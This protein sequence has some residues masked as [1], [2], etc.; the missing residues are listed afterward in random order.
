MIKL[1]R[2][3]GL[4]VSRVSHPRSQPDQPDCSTGFYSPCE[5]FQDHSGEGE[6]SKRN[7][8][9]MVHKI[10]DPLGILSPTTLLPVTRILEIEVKMG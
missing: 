5:D 1:A 6:I 4:G 7:I 2:I 9:A 8:L 3:T 10:F